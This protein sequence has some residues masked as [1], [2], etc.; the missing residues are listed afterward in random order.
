MYGPTIV[1]PSIRLEQPRQEDIPTFQRWFADLEVT[2]YLVRRSVPSA[3][4]E[5]EWLQQSARSETDVV[6]R[7]VAGDRTIGVTGLHGIDWMNRHATSGTIIG[8]KS[9]WGKGYARELVLLRTRYAFEELGLE[10]LETESFAVNTPMHR[11]L[12]RAGYQRM[13][14]RRHHMYRGG[15]WHDTVLFELLSTEWEGREAG[16]G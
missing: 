7:I 9:E 16:A 15:R 3:E 8:E 2:R 5:Q 11:A 12:M 14:T 4:Q 1:G 10:R 6:W 13:G